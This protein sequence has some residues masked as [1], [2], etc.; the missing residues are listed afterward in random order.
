MITVNHTT[1]NKEKISKNR[2]I[3]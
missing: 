2:R 1:V 3:T